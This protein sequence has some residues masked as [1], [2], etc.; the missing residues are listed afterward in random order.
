MHYTGNG[1]RHKFTMINDIRTVFWVIS[2]DQAYSSSGYRYVLSDSTKH[3]HWHNNNNGKLFGSH[4]NSHVKN[5]TTRLNG[6][7]INGTNTDQPTNLSIL[8]VKTTGNTDAD[9]FGYDRTITSRQW[10][11]KLGELIIFNTALSDSDIEKV[12]CQLANKWCLTD[13]LPNSHPYKFA[14]PISVV[15]LFIRCCRGQA[16][17]LSLL[18]PLFRLVV[19]M[20]IQLRFNVGKGWRRCQSVISFQGRLRSR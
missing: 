20:E 18:L 13:S 7:I 19:Q 17:D 6:S 11:G 2:I 3:P 5:G 16:L 10:I 12:E 9:Q 14:L 8:T 1:Q 4:S 15:I